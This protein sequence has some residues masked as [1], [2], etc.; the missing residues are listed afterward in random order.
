MSKPRIITIIVIILILIAWCIF[1]MTRYG[2]Q[3]QYSAPE[4]VTI[5]QWTPDKNINES[6]FSDSNILIVYFTRSNHTKTIVD[7]IHDRV[8]WDIFEIQTAEPYPESYAMVADTAKWWQNS[9]VRPELKAIRNIDQYD[10]I[11]IGTPIRWGTYPMPMFTYFESQNWEGKTI[12][13]FSTHEWSWL[14]NIIKD[15][16][17]STNAKEYK[18]WLAIDWNKVDTA[19][20]EVYAWLEK[21]WF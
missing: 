5:N 1:Y 13:P 6:D 12:I 16:Q 7:Y 4:W 21:L 8:W 19:K 18:E 9:N 3:Y 14:W 15:I 20:D 10:T 17:A 2:T 11:F